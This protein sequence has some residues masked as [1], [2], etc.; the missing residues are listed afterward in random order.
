MRTLNIV[1]G[2]PSIPPQLV[3]ADNDNID[4][5][6]AE[7]SNPDGWAKVKEHSN[8]SPSKESFKNKLAV[9]NQETDRLG[10]PFLYKST[11]GIY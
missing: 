5:T 11:S 10:R 9:T 8:V 7:L 2:V 1:E 4:L 6:I 3:L